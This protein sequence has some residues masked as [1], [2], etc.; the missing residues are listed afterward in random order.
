LIQHHATPYNTASAQHVSQ[1][2]E[3]G[4]KEDQQDKTPAKYSGPSHLLALFQLHLA[5]FLET[6]SLDADKAGGIDRFKSANLIH[7]ALA[8]IIQLLRVAASTENIEA[9]FIQSAAND[10]IDASL[11]GDDAGFE[12]LALGREVQAVVEDFGVVEGHELVA[13]SADFAVKD[14]AFEVDV[15]RSETGQPRCLVAASRLEADEAV[16]DNVSAAHAVLAGQGVDGQEELDG[17]GDGLGSPVDAV[18]ESCREAFA[19]CEG[20]VQGCRGSV[21]RVRGELPHVFWRCR[22]WIFEDSSFVGAVSKILIHGPWFGFCRGHWDTHLGGI[23]EEVIPACKA[24]VE[25]R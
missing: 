3:H 4:K 10:S 8:G 13:E 11:R 17:V 24:L 20:K 6:D 18:G 16:L 19:E 12:E 9:S 25:L 2:A 15:G 5:I 7:G 14:Q 22:V 23:V 21:E 1:A